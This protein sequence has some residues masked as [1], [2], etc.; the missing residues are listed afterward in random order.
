MSVAA[1]LAKLRAAEPA[2]VLSVHNFYNVPGGEDQVFAAEQSLLR[3]EGH[4]VDVF[5]DHNSRIGSAAVAAGL[6]AIWNPQ[7]YRRLEEVV[8]STR[9]DIVHFHNIFPLISPAAY[10]AARKGGAAVVQTL[11]NYR[12][13][14]P[15][16]T[17]FRDGRTCEECI[18]QR[19][20]T[21][22][23]IHGCYR[24]S[25][26]A[27]TAVAAMLVTHRAAGTWTRMVDS[28]IALSDFA[29]RKYAEGGLPEAR[30]HVKS[31]FVS[32]VPGPSQKTRLESRPYA[33][34]AGRLVEEKGVPVLANAWRELA[35]EPSG[36][37][38]LLAG[39]GPLQE[40][41]LPS[42]VTVLGQQTRE[43]VFD[44]MRNAEFLIFPSVCYECN[45]MT[46]LEAFASGLPVIASDLGAM[47]E[48]V[49]HGRTG[50]LF[51]SGDPQDL[52]RSVRWALEH[53]RELAAMRLEARKEYEA[54]YTPERNYTQLMEIYRAALSR[55]RARSHAPELAQAATGQ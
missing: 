54:K 10:Y 12:L 44:L 53:P 26:S 17:L 38:L 4:S 40:T 49:D 21:P 31:N 36:L 52:A 50:L 48:L 15:G 22:A 51:R 33:L 13:L 19:S 45:P 14:C 16:A 27:T 23:L 29:K 46:I 34:F 37:P 1:K 18:E 25:R 3:N 24:Q 8:R 39:T 47:R 42:N 32:D 20:L 11:H 28:Y 2:R 7:S 43:Q 41:A 35:G 55:S 9:P 30:L 5:E 6:R